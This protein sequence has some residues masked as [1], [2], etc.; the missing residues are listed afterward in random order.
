MVVLRWGAA[1]AEVLPCA[2][3][4]CRR[5]MAIVMVAMAR[6]RHSAKSGGRV[7]KG[8]VTPPNALVR[9]DDADRC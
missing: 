8:A 4:P 6:K 2:D 5:W 1:T 7:R 9:R 3:Q